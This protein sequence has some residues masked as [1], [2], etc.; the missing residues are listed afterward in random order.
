MRTTH[1]GDVRDLA[2]GAGVNYLGFIARLGARAPFLLLAGRLYGASL[3][4]AY[5]FGT[6]IVE[7]AAGMAVFGMKRSLLKFMSE[8]AVRR[9]PVHRS[10]AH[11]LALAM[12]TATVATI[13]V[14]AGAG[15]LSTTFGLPTAVDAL[16]WLTPAIPMI[17]VSD[18]LLSAISFQ[19][20]MGFEVW[21]RS[22]AEPVTL[23]V[24]TAV[25]YFA[26]ARDAGLMMAYVASLAVAAG[27]SIVFFARMFPMGACV[28][29]S[30]R[31]AELRRMIRFNAP[32]AGYEFLVSLADRA[33]VLLVA[34]FSPAGV[35]GVYGMARQL[36]TVSRKIRHGFDRILPPVFS[37]CIAS[38]NFHRAETHLRMVSRWI[39]SVQVLVVLGVS[40]YA[41]DLLG[42]LGNQFASGSAILVLLLVAEA[43]NSSLGVSELPIIYL[44]PALNVVLGLLMV[45]VILVIGVWLIGIMGPEGVATALIVAYTLVNALR[46]SVNRQLFQI[47]GVDRA[48]LKPVLAAAPAVG[49]LV[50]LRRLSVGLPTLGEVLALPLLIT[51]YLGSL[52]LLGLEPSDHAQIRRMVRKFQ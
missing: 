50:V 13:A 38:G 40:F 51:I 10:I 21:A 18:V 42:L 30:L 9:E 19:R 16:L 43:I 26:G 15:W 24:A 36:A 3:F 14:G 11:G 6:A 41:A 28:R 33:D 20:K 12:A 27:V 8:A 17:V 39:L 31:W 5:T 25:A 52:Y 29:E 1:D 32:T 44:K 23:T 4:G 46:I 7:T 49:C 48:L 2:R 34:Y 22:I 37:Q 35:V 47:T 45:F